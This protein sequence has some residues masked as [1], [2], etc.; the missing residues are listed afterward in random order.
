[1]RPDDQKKHMK[2]CKVLLKKRLKANIK[3]PIL[4][5]EVLDTYDNSTVKIQKGVVTDT[6]KD[7]TM[8]ADNPWAINVDSVSN[9]VR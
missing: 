1:M 6:S 2:G 9:E 4:A 5:H 3:S 7:Y 8:T